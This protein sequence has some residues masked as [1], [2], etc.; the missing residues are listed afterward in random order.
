[1]TMMDMVVMMT[2]VMMMVM[3]MRLG[4]CRE[5]GAASVGGTS[6]LLGRLPAAPSHPHHLRCHHIFIYL[7]RSSLNRQQ[8]HH[9]HHS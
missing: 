6:G 5:M 3:M 2:T 8:F 7:H 9:H 4:A 1:M